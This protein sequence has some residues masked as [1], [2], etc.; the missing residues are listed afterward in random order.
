LANALFAATG[1]RIRRLPIRDQFVARNSRTSA[2]G[3]A[4]ALVAT[5]A[6]PS[7]PRS[8]R[9]HRYRWMP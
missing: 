3:N 9:P 5:L 2:P 6:R 7:L 1:K 4:G 8:C